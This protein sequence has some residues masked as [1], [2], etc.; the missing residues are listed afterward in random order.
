MLW[1][2]AALL[3]R[4]FSWGLTS[5]VQ[6][7]DKAPASCLRCAWSDDPSWAKCRFSAGS[8]FQYAL[9]S[10]YYHIDITNI[11]RR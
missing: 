9:A 11:T 6:A 3:N 2:E 10:G 4:A 5:P 1:P 7:T 8:L